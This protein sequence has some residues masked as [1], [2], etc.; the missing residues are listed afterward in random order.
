DGRAGVHDQRDQNV[1]IAFHRVCE[2]SIT[3]RNDDLKKIGANGEMSRNPENINHRGHAD[4]AGAAAEKTA[5]KSTYKR[6]REHNPERNRLY[7][8]SRQRDHRPNFQS[9]NGTRDGT[10]CGMVSFCLRAF[11]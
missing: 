2:S 8:R 11:Y 3:G 4:V 9:L 1:Y 6:Y 10:E 7:S 5:E